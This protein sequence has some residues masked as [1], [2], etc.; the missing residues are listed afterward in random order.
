MKERE[1]DF[2]SFTKMKLKKMHIF[3]IKDN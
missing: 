2:Y 3:M 1:N